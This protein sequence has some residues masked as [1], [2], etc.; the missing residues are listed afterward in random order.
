M[1]RG[2][3]LTQEEKS[4]IEAYTDAGFSQ[5]QIAQKMQR[6]Q[7]VV[8][9]FM[10]LGQ[11]YGKNATHDRNKNLND[12]QKRLIFRTVRKQDVFASQLVKELNYQ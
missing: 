10:L 12:H 9:N 8:R 4:K 2:T 7:T 11:N 5:W 6:S 3:V 1:P